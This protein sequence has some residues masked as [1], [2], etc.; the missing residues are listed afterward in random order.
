MTTPDAPS[1]AASTT[2]STTP[3]TDSPLMSLYRHALGP[4]GIERNI[5]VFSQFEATGRTRPGWNGAAAFLTLHWMVFYR[6]WRPAG[7]YAFLAALLLGLFVL[8]DAATMPT[9]ASVRWWLL[10]AFG[11]VGTL[12]PGLYGDALLYAQTELRVHNAIAASQTLAQARTLLARRAGSNRRMGWQALAHVLLLALGGVLALVG[13]APQQ[14]PLLS[15]QEPEPTMASPLPPPTPA[16]APILPIEGAAAPTVAVSPPPTPTP[17]VSAPVVSVAPL[18]EKTVSSAQARLPEAAAVVPTPEQPP[19]EE[20]RRPAK[21]AIKPA[22]EPP[23]PQAKVYSSRDASQPAPVPMSAPA[24]E[25]APAR[26]NAPSKT[27]AKTP[28]KVAVQAA[29]PATKPVKTVADEKEK[30]KAT[31]RFFIHA[32]TFA[33][34]SNAEKVHTRI[35]R[36]GLPATLQNFT[37]ADKNLIRVRVGPFASRAEAERAAA[38]LR[39]MGLD[40]MIYGR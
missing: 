34:A 37:N 27:P 9:L 11:V 7:L 35:E 24:P 5:R 23:K 29:R 21:V 6:L 22:P 20:A 10:L 18:V 40:A 32:G 30:D 14:Q 12:L 25:P 3:T 15:S 33:L 28:G 2:S 36:A 38:K 17:P 26:P 39:A 8:V 1:P 19:I 13:M 31:G 4:V 16:P